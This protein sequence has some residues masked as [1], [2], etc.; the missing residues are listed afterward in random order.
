MAS[1]ALDTEAAEATWPQPVVHDPDPET[2]A[3][4]VTLA[5]PIERKGRE[6]RGEVT[7]RRLRGEDMRAT[8]SKRGEDR[9]YEL[10][11]RAGGLLP[12][13]L[14]AMDIADLLAVTG[15]VDGFF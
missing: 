2:G 6:P 8:S 7:I 1:D 13:E 14:D 9:T 11:I 10:T 15:V 4:R 3:V 5:M 12:S